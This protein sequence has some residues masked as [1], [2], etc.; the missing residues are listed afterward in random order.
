VGF[1]G[2]TVLRERTNPERI[3]PATPIKGDN[4]SVNGVNDRSR[5]RFRI[6]DTITRKTPFGEQL[7]ETKAKGERSKRP[8]AKRSASTLPDRRNN[9]GKEGEVILTPW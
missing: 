6:V 9:G 8:G 7:L 1:R 4:T 5:N 2:C 3:G